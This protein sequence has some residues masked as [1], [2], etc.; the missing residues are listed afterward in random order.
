MEKKVIVCG[1]IVV[2]V[3]WGIYACFRLRRGRGGGVPTSAPD[4]R[5]SG[6]V[7]FLFFCIFCLYVCFCLQLSGWSCRVC[8][9]DLAFIRSVG[10]GAARAEVLGEGSW[11]RALVGCW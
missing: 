6:L 2:A 9:G 5:P 10:I 8:D 11:V 4:R 3:A 7:R 1:G